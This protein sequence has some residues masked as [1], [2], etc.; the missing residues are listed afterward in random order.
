MGK[1][2]H[3]INMPHHVSK[4][5]KKMTLSDRAAQFAPF[6]ALTGY[7]DSIKESARI[8]DKQIILSNEDMNKISN[9]LNYIKENIDKSIEINVTYFILDNKKDGGS[10]KNKIGVIRSIDD[11]NKT[12]QFVD[13][14]IIEI[15]K[16][17]KITSDCFDE[18][19]IY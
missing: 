15:N 18:F 13:R 5:R 11:V 9:R 1:Y 8:V 17:I 10:Y 12:I 16:I 7:E 14:Q 19:E 6:A 3:I 2:D 4:N